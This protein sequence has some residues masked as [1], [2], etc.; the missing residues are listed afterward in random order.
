MRKLFHKLNGPRPTNGWLVC[1]VD[2]RFA[3]AV[4]VFAVLKLEAIRQRLVIAGGDR[5]KWWLE[6]HDF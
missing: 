3:G 2:G 4:E 5:E 1:S 6:I